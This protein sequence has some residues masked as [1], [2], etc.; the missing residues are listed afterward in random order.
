MMMESEDYE[1]MQRVLERSKVLNDLIQEMEQDMPLTPV[2]LEELSAYRLRRYAEE[3]FYRKTLDA[4]DLELYD[5]Y[6]AKY[7]AGMQAALSAGANPD[8]RICWEGE[9]LAA[10]AARCGW[11]DGAE[12]LLDAGA[13]PM[14]DDGELL[15]ALCCKG[16][17][18]LLKK[19][20]SLC[21]LPPDWQTAPDY[22][23]LATCAAAAGQV[24]CLRVLRE[25][26]MDLL[27]YDGEVL[28]EACKGNWPEVVSYLLCD[29][30]ASLE[31]EYDDWSPLFYA[32]QYDALDC[33]RILLEVGAN[34]LHEDICGNTPFRWAASDNMLMLLEE[35]KRKRRWLMLPSGRTS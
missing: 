25:C 15:I 4:P 27:A 1:T 19:A 17:A 18:R 9:P 10:D 6:E 34:P 29:C 32:A 3:C 5:S 11:F 12:L 8:L 14:E 26:G 28:C 2:A 7:P 21:D 33:A 22:W 31:E 35:A 24:D 13:S 20:L 16:E 23:S 30:G